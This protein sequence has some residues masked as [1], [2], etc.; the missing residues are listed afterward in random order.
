MHE[1]ATDDLPGVRKSIISVLWAQMSIS[2]RGFFK[3]KHNGKTHKGY[4]LPYKK[5][6]CL[7]SNKTFQENK[8]GGVALISQMDT[9][10]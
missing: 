8:L 4:D 7:H 1:A 6:F 2:P 9:N 10:H 5:N 3:K